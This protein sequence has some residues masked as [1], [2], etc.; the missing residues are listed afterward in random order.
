M[1]PR[2]NPVDPVRSKAQKLRH[3]RERA[4]YQEWVMRPENEGERVKAFLF[5]IVLALALAAAGALTLLGFKTG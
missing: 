1:A 3:S 5:F 4:E 2:K